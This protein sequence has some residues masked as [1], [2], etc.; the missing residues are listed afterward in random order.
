MSTISPKGTALVIGGSGGIGG[1]IC[2]VLAGQGWDIALTYLSN[3]ARAEA[4]VKAI[5]D[6]GGTARA[7]SLDLA[8]KTA[9]PALIQAM[10]A[11][12][13]ALNA[14]VYAAGP[15]IDLVHLS[16]TD[17]DLMERHL[18]ADTMGFFR[19]AHAALPALRAAG[20]SVVCCLSAAQFRYAPA[21]GLSVVPKSAVTAVM[22]GI[23][24][25]EG[26]FGVRANGVATGLIEA[27]Q[28]DALIASGGID[29]AY[30]EAAARATPLR[31]VGKPED[32]AEAVAFFA[33][34]SRS[35]FVTGQVIA[36][37]GGYSV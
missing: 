7:Y 23:A 32:I 19:V 24:K 4:T 9:A 13:G 17:P 10:T 3:V 16:R 33:D 14:L 22:K 2:K 20:G 21:D 8:D 30:M 15:L 34:S 6:A 11:E 27:G 5:T 31:R 28:M 1:V 25:E 29:A 37:D 36:V 18:L 26:R 35:G 12:C